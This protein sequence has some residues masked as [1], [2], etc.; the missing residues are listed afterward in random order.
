MQD[1][2]YVNINHSRSKDQTKALNEIQ[3]K[4]FCP[5]CDKNYL[6]NE[7]KKPIIKEGSFW[8][9]TENRWVYEGAKFHFLFIHKKHLIDFSEIT[10]EAWKELKVLTNFISEK[11]KIKGATLILRHGDTSYNGATVAHLHAQLIS[12]DPEKEKPVITRVG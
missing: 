1:K 6:N 3:K 2:K 12:G 5:F 7:H 11:Y 9:I 10:T 4:V 8:L